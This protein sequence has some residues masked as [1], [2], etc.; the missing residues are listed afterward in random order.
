MTGSSGRW[1]RRKITVAALASIGVLALLI[2]TFAGVVMPFFQSD[3][4]DLAAARQSTT[5]T[6]TIA[7]VVIAPLAVRPVVEAFEAQPGQCDP[8]PP[9]MPPVEPQ[10]ACDVERKAHYQL[11]P[12][13]VQLGLTGAR[14]VQL[15]M[16]EFYSV[17]L[18]MDQQSSAAFA[19]YTSANIGRQVAF[20]RDGL[21]LAAPSITQTVNGQS[22]QLSGD[23]TRATAE[24]IAQLVL[25]GS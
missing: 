23:M 4:N 2:T 16:S 15:P 17:Q 25:D 12:V 7:P 14:A 5:P 24:T 13:T 21:V 1:S 11:E 19:Q 3:R 6:S 10:P 22:I 18:V 20:M 9:P 8:P